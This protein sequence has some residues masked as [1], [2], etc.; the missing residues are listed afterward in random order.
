MLSA[1][2]RLRQNIIC[3]SIGKTIYWQTVLDFIQAYQKNQYSPNNEQQKRLIETA[4][5]TPMK[6]TQFQWQKNK[7]KL[8]WKLKKDANCVTDLIPAINVD[9]DAY[10]ISFGAVPT[11]CFLLSVKTRLKIDVNIGIYVNCT[12]CVICDIRVKS[13]ITVLWSQWKWLQFL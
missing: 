12:T 9:S 2:S 8:T 6:S 3:L 13:P 1:L 4:Q 7:L 5:Y 10:S 11:R